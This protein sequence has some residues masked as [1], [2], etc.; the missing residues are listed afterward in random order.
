M[1]TNSTY[2]YKDKEDDGNRGEGDSKP[3]DDD[4]TNQHNVEN[5]K[6]SEP[7]APTFSYSIKDVPELHRNI[8]EHA[9][10]VDWDIDSPWD[11][12]VVSVNEGGF[13]V[14]MIMYLISKIGSGKSAVPLTIATI[15]RGITIVVVQLLGLG[16]DQVKKASGLTRTLVHTSVTNSVEKMEDCSGRV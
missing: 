5:G 14:N 16:S 4:Y 12:Q 11:F 8:I 15:Q 7:A 6:N 2:K 13:Q 9:M 1:D 3:N 10:N